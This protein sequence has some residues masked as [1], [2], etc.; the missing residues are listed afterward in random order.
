MCAHSA[1]GDGG[2]DGRSRGAAHELY[3]ASIEK[4]GAS[5]EAALAHVPALQDAGIKQARSR[6]A[7]LSIP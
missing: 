3:D 5:L 4:A 2:S 7:C 6:V 1:P